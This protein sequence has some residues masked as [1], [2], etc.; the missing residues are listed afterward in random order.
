MDRVNV[1]VGLNFSLSIHVN[2]RRARQIR[3]HRSLLRATKHTRYYSSCQGAAIE[4]P[5]VPQHGVRNGREGPA[6]LQP[7]RPERGGLL[8][9]RVALLAGESRDYRAARPGHDISRRYQGKSLSPSQIPRSR[10]SDRPVALAGEP[11]L[12]LDHVRSDADIPAV[13][14]QLHGR[15]LQDTDHVGAGGDRRDRVR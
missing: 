12:A 1:L 8:E 11:R 13:D 15:E 14:S 10:R 2:R 4:G 9:F 7:D 3:K 6:V 5:A